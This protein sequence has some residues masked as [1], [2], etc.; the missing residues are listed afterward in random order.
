M[1]KSTDI[2]EHPSSF[3]VMK[4]NTSDEFVSIEYFV[5]EDEAV[6][7]FEENEK[8]YDYVHMYR[9]ERCSEIIEEQS[10]PPNL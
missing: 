7:C 2:N 9:L 6:R 10:P 3:A 5:R 8:V 1:N 4:S